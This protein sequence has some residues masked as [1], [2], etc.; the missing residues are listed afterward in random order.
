MSMDSS[1]HAIRRA[2]HVVLVMHA[3][4]AASQ[5]E[6]ATPL[7]L[8]GEVAVD[9][10]GHGATIAMTAS[11]GQPLRQGIHVEARLHVR[12]PEA[13]PHQRQ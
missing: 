3:R 5:L 8:H 10:G 7:D 4:Q 13:G 2:V 11:P 12:A 9:A 1:R 6:R